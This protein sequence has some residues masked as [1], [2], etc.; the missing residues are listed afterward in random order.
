[1]KSQVV[2]ETNADLEASH[3][4][5]TNN[6]LVVADRTQKGL[7]WFRFRENRT[8]FQLSP[9]GKLQVKWN[10]ISEKK[11]L[12]KL[13]K[14]LLIAKANEKLVIKP[15][16]QQAW[17]EY[18]VPRSFKLY[19]C[20]KTSE[21]ALKESVENGESPSGLQIKPISQALPGED[22]VEKVL[23]ELA[24]EQNKTTLEEVAG[25]VGFPPSD[26]EKLVYL[27][28]RRHGWTTSRKQ[29]GELEIDFK[30]PVDISAMKFGPRLNP[31]HPYG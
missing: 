21:F 17:I 8:V 23:V 24:E 3:E 1:M 4:A 5:M 14:I 27:L 16:R 20:D 11:T 15:L 12:Y 19:W 26:I 31:W 25:K 29:N 9:L 18:P 22:E 10:D 30:K 6:P 13:V 2:Y 28:V 7:L